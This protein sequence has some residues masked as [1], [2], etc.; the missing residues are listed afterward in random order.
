VTAPRRVDELIEDGP[1]PLVVPD[2]RSRI[3][4]LHAQAGR[5]FVVL[6][7]DPTGSQCV[8]DVE[9]VVGTGDAL[10]RAVRE[11]ASTAFVLT[12]TRS[13]GE[14]QAVE[15]T[16]AAA[17][18]VNRLATRLEGPLSIVSRGD[19]TLRGHVAAELAALDAAYR[20][21][22]GGGYDALLIAPAYLE[23]GRF[24]AA[25]VHWA[26][27]GGTPVPVGETEFSR[28]AT[29]GYRSSDLREYVE[30]QTRGRVRRDAVMSLSL[31]DIRIGGPGRVAELLSSARDGRYVVVN[32]TDYA[33][34]D[35][36]AL[37]VA[38]L[39]AAGHAFGVRCGPSFVPALAGIAPRD[40]LASSELSPEGSR[41][42]GLVVV[43]SHVGL[44][45]TQVVAAQARG[46]LSTVE[47]DAAALVDPVQARRQH[48]RCVAAA[49]EALQTS[50]VLLMTSRQLRRSDDAQASL[51]ISRGVSAAVSDIVRDVLA[52]RPAWVVAKGGITSHD[53]A[54]H[55]L[56][57]KRGVVLGQLLPGMVSVV[58]PL[59][60]AAEAVG[61]PYVVFA[62]NV[63]GE[64]TLA[65]IV[66][67]MAGRRERAGA[68]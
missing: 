39:M 42:H 7:D 12:N 16:T 8:H 59:D 32:A 52:A 56:G 1:A 24:T 21:G 50:D 46:G 27:V 65:D 10:A 62:G 35:V 30:E 64:D 66:D 63:G 47:V 48:E 22:S 55:G 20:R 67:T 58:R 14:G 29:F 38:E 40:V 60:A 28:D 3:R 33:D 11:P 44:T 61:M 31:D 23:A 68:P 43:G 25:D 9:L 4:L 37:A 15:A 17:D 41:G 57:L 19:S 54:V 5:R 34:L 45:T 51:A 6:D 36:V 13:M 49:T 18:D 26:T 53:V 2:V